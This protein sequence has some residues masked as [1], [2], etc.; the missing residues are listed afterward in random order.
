VDIKESNALK[1]DKYYKLY[2]IIISFSFFI[3]FYFGKKNRIKMKKNE[4][5]NF[6]KNYI[7]LF[8]ILNF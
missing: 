1:Y 7:V 6:K 3:G 2:T 5:N 8:H 4:E